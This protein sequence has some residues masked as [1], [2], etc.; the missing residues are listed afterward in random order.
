MDFCKQ[1]NDKTKHFIQGMR[2]SIS[3]SFCSGIPIAARITVNPD[4]T[5]SF[6]T[7][8]PP[9]SWLLKQALGIEKGTICKS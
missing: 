6:I 4:K 1:F 8:T 7:K 5:Y 3:N 9:T 2:F